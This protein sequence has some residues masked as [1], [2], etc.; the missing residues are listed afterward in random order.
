MLAM[1]TATATFNVAAW[2]MANNDRLS[3]TRISL[4][5]I[6]LSTVLFFGSLLWLIMNYHY[7]GRSWWKLVG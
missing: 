2:G 5:I 6:G 7:N 1:T 3:D 4:L